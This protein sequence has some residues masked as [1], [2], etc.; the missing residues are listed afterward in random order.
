MHATHQF[1]LTRRSLYLLV[2]NG[3]QGQEEHDADYWLNLIQSFGGDSPVVVVLNKIKLH[4][5]DV[6]RR[7]LRQKFPEI[8]DF[9]ATDCADG[10]GLDDLRQII[11]RE[12]DRL[13]GLRDAFPASW[14]A[15]K[16][17][18][19]GMPEN[20]L[21]FPEYQKICSGLGE[22]DPEAQESLAGH[23]HRLGLALNY[24][25]DPRLRDMHVLNPH[26]LTE[27]V[28]QILRAETVAKNQG[29]LQLNDLAGILD[30]AAYPR[31]RQPFLL[32]LMRR[33][34][35][36]FSFPDEEGHYLLPDL[37]DKQEPVASGDF[38]PAA[39]LNFRYEYPILP[40]GLL[41]RFIVRTHVLSAGQPRWRTGVI[42]KFEG[43]Q[44]L[45]KADKQDKTVSILVNGPQSGRRRLLAVI[46]SDFDHLHRS[47]TFQPQEMV[48]LPQYPEAAVSYQE[49]LAF[50]A[51][52]VKKF[53]KM[54]MG[55]VFSLERAGI[56]QRRGP[57]RDPRSRAGERQGRGGD[58]G[59][60]Q[61]FPQ[62]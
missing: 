36:C 7:G 48:P 39:C 58:P 20:Y 25:D 23:L 10:S 27:G 56:A 54:V 15:I 41:P 4:A 21:T 1:F 3:R 33:F 13:P 22:T 59:V 35:L 37:L 42:L 30:P 9:V 8:A 28:Y 51:N 62:R 44:A 2:L 55:Q 29:E 34:E 31:D 14:F 47:F 53:P 38:Q 26:W 6:N 43:C 5:F 60:R 57:G 32:D 12:T 61:L 49:L 45:V 11:Q 24:K 16:E 18:L 40:E 50:E 19:A 17:R 46:R 52:G